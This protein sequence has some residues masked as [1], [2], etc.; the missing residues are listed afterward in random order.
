MAYDG[1]RNQRQQWMEPSLELIKGYRDMPFSQ[2]GKYDV[3]FIVEFAKQI[4]DMLTGREGYKVSRDENKS[5]QL[6]K[7]Y[8]F[9]RRIE[10]AMKANQI[11]YEEAYVNYSETSFRAS[12]LTG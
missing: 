1:R 3:R 12:C 8:E 4:S 10:T 9:A 5:S 2:N 6:R 7:Y 11:G